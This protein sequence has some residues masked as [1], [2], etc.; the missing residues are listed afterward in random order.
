[1]AVTISD[2]RLA[3]Y[4]E[5]LAKAKSAG[6]RAAVK[7][8]ERSRANQFKS[9][10]EMLVGAAGVGFARGKMEEPDGTWNIPGTGIDYE[11]VLGGALTGVGL[12]QYA[13]VYSDDLLNI[14][15]GILAHY[16]GQL[17]RKYA[18]TGTFTLVAGESAYSHNYPTVAGTESSDDL[19]A[20]MQ[21][22]LASTIG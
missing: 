9:S 21:S 1:M 22:A 16:S 12:L 19:G 6:K 17:A 7:A 2:A 4:K 15:S 20:A 10:A 13:G 11:M 18:K 5:T 14:G 8:R 3:Q